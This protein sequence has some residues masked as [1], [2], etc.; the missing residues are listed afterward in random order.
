MRSLP[1]QAGDQSDAER[2]QQTILT[3]A[4]AEGHVVVTDLVAHFG[5]APETIR[6]DLKALAERGV[7]Q[8]VYGGA[9][10]LETGGFETDLGFRATSHIGEKHRIAAA[11]AAR[12]QG[13]ETV[14]IDEGQTP[15]FIA[16]ELVGTRSSTG[17]MTVVTPS[18]PVAERLAVEPGVTVLLL[19]GRVRGQTLATVEPWATRMLDELVID[20]AYIGA[21][22][23]SRDH[24]VTTPDPAVAAV[25]RAAIA[26]SRRRILFGHHTKF[27]A[28]S[29]CRFADATDFEVIVTG[30]EL[31][32][33]D[34]HRY[35]ALGTPVIR[36]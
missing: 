8:R 19:G 33:S 3:R 34:A 14:Y 15:V 9:V 24:G 12:R 25:K 28:S 4:R 17:P 11:C 13:A 20:L 2:R 35:A 31:T 1:G 18:L 16:D 6:R 21:N 7:V 23:I 30:V 22:G 29:L 26:R 10:A 32:A 27:G 36:A 5:V